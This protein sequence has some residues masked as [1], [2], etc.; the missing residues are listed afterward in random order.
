M[1]TNWSTFRELLLPGHQRRR[2]VEAELRRAIRDGRLPP[3]TRLPSSRDLAAQLDVARGTVTSAYTQ[4]VA[5]GYLTTRRGS[6]TTVA[7]LGPAGDSGVPE[8]PPRWRY[9]LRPGLPAL[10]AFPRAEWVAAHRAALAELPDDDLAY[11][12]PAGFAGL[13][14]EVVDYLARVRA[15]VA[16]DAVIT[17][18]SADGLQLTARVLGGSIAIEEPSHFGGE[19]MLRSHGL[20]TV[21]IPVDDKGIRV[22]LLST[23]DCKAVLVTA[24]H[25][26][27]LGVVLH[28][29]R[30]RALVDWARERDALIIEDDYDAEHRYDRPALGALQALAPEHVVYQG[31]TSKVL[32]PALRLGWLVVPER[33]RESIVQRKQYNDMGTGTIP[34]AAFAHLLRTGGYDRHLRRTRALYRKRRDALLDAVAEHLPAWQPIG[35]AAGL[36]VVLRMP[37]GTDDLALKSRLA[38]RGVNVWALAQ[39]TRTP[40]WPGLVVGYAALTPD[41]LR[42]AVREIAAA[43]VA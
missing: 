41:R 21:P 38:D 28:P 16:K 24:A 1:T 7:S 22:D 27:P 17:N 18:G 8:P 25:Q 29:E 3:G 32:A 10:G 6:G 43:S 26:F 33:L 42:E 39:Y 11:P 20:D 19:N 9:N 12:D 36:H 5:E 30:R 31:T 40:T 37:D 14:K 13:R 35:V 4:L 34:Q 15:V 23:T 2:G